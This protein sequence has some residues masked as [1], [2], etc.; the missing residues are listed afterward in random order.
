M[1]CSEVYY[2]KPSKPAINTRLLF[3]GPWAE[4]VRQAEDSADVAG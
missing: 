1:S 2:S 4:G 3:Q